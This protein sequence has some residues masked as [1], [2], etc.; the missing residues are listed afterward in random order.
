MV[1]KSVVWRGVDRV[2]VRLLPVYHPGTGT[3]NAEREN[4]TFR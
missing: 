4:K 3:K 1:L 2:R